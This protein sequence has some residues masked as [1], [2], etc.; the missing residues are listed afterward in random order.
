MLIIIRSQLNMPRANS[1]MKNVPPAIFDQPPS[2]ICSGFL[3]RFGVWNNGSSGEKSPRSTSLFSSFRLRLSDREFRSILLLQPRRSS[4]LLSSRSLHLVENVICCS[5]AAVVI[6][7]RSFRCGCSMEF[8]RADASA[9]RTISETVPSDL[10]IDIKYSF[11]DW[12]RHLVL[13]VQTQNI[14][15][16]G[17]RRSSFGSAATTT[18]S[19]DGSLTRSIDRWSETT[20]WQKLL[21]DRPFFTFDMFVHRS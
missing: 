16:C 20:D 15:R 3:D 1:T 14:L 5:S 13:V 4:L 19:V 18:A 9:I 8:V 12:H 10:L 17:S 6:G 11:P 21:V 2:T 7:R